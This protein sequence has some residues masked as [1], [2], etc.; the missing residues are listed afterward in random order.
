M[1][2]WDV[3]RYFRSQLFLFVS[4]MVVCNFSKVFGQE[5]Y[6]DSLRCQLERDS[7]KIFRVKRYLPILIVDTRNS[8][9][10]SAK[11]NIVGVQAGVVFREKDIAGIG[12]YKIYL[13]FKIVDNNNLYRLRVNYFT[14]FYQKVLLEK[15]F[16]E[17]DVMGEAG[18][19]G[20]NVHRLENGQEIF[21][22]RGRFNSMGV[23]V[24]NTFKALKWLGLQSML[25]YRWMLQ[26]EYYSTFSGWF[27]SLGIWFSV[28]DFV[29]FIRYDCLAKRKYKKCVKNITTQKAGY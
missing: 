25:G 11:V 15:R 9:I 10:S 3:E 6:I 24:V 20:F 13:P 2:G 1:S 28:K 29:R 27:Y 17:V 12:G 5:A 7:V 14:L 19:G 23:S 18:I 16:F 4:I 8:F 22:K 21:V 26:K